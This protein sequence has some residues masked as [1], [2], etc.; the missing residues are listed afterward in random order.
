MADVYVEVQAFHF[1]LPYICC[2]KRDMY[3]LESFILFY[4]F[5]ACVCVF[6]LGKYLGIPCSNQQE[7]KLP[8]CVMARL[9]GKIK[10]ELF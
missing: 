3:F 10:F 9:P 1:N 7:Q 6:P 2:E 4:D 8:A 5:Y